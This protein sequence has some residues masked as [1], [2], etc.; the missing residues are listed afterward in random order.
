VPSVIALRAV[1]NR[2]LGACVAVA[3]CWPTAEAGKAACT[4]AARCRTKHP[5]K[6]GDPEKLGM[7]YIDNF[8]NNANVSV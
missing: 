6:R 3:E 2:D 1:A 4:V 5:A 8:I 7:R